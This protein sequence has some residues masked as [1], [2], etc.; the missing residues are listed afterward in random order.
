MAK[1]KT[2]LTCEEM[3]FWKDGVSLLKLFATI[4]L[5]LLCCPIADYLD[6][7]VYKLG[8]LFFFILLCVW[9]IFFII[10]FESIWWQNMDY[11]EWKE[12]YSEEY[13]YAGDENNESK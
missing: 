12:K 13:E 1:K 4:P 2:I 3:W 5:L 9:M 8:T 6:S 7:L 10:R 11:T